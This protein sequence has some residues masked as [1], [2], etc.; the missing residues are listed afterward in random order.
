ML[1]GD[2]VAVPEDYKAVYYADLLN[3]ELVTSV[4]MINYSGI[5]VLSMI[6]F[7]GAYYLQ[8]HF[9]NDIDRDIFWARL[10][11]GFIIDKLGVK[12]LKHFYKFTKD[13]CKEYRLLVFD[14]H[15]SYLNQKFLDFCWENK[16]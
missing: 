9:Y 16:I 15:S 2:L 3:R 12:Y 13:I 14:R 11:T 4:E 6:I 10:E 7:K 1:D 5:K 8:K